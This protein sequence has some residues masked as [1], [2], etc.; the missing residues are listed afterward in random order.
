MFDYLHPIPSPPKFTM[1]AF[2][3]NDMREK[4]LRN[5]EQRLLQKLPNCRNPDYWRTHDILL[6][7]AIVKPSK[8]SNPMTETQIEAIRNLGSKKLGRS[9]YWYCI[10]DAPHIVTNNADVSKGVANGTLAFLQDMKD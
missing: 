2:P 1:A 6:V 10:V 5:C 7:K 3:F 9:G 4:A 8:T